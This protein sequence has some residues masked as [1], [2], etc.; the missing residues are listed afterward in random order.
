VA[1]AH[2]DDAVARLGVEAERPAAP[3]LSEARRR[4]FGGERWAAPDAPARDALRGERR[5]DPV[6]E[7]GGIGL[8][9]DMLE[10]AAAAFREMTAGRRLAV[11]A[12]A[13]RRR[14]PRPDRPARSAAR[15]GRSAVTPS[16]RA[17]QRS[18]D[19]V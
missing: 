4:L 9:V 16:P 11:R 10:L 13:R 18:D 17:G 15:S 1:F 3:L 2:V 8:V 7:V 6:D 14:R 19:L 12:R 5:G